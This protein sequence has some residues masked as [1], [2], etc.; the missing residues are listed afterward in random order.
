MSETPAD[1][2]FADYLTVGEAAAALGVSPWTLRNWDR[3]GKLRTLRH[4]KNGYR[5]YRREDLNAVLRP[6]IGAV[7]GG[8]PVLGDGNPGHF[9]QFF[10]NDTYLVATVGEFIGAALGRGEG[11]IVIATAAHRRGL[12]KSLTGRGID[13]ATA[14]QGGQYVALDAAVTLAAFMDGD[15]PDPQRF[16]EVVGGVVART[17]QGRAG[18]S[19]FGEMVALLWSAGNRAGAIRL[20][21]LWNDLARTQTFALLCAYP[22]SGFG[23]GDHVEG[24]ADVCA[25]HTRVLPAESF[26]RLPTEDDRLR[27]IS[28]LQQQARAL[29][30]E[31]ERRKAAE[32][33]LRLADRRKDEFLATLAHE[34]RNPLAP[35]CTALEVLQESPADRAAAEKAVATMGRQV[36]QLVRLVDDLLDVS[37]ITRGKVELRTERVALAAVVATAVEMSRPQIEAARH[38]LTVELPP[39]EL[40]LDADPARL[41]QMLSNLLNNAAKYTDAGGRIRVRAERQGDQV[42]V[43]VADTGIGIAPELLP[44]VF[45][46]FVQADGLAERANGGLGVGLALVKALAQLHGGTVEA[47]SDGPGRGSEFTLRLPLAPAAAPK[48][49][50]GNGRTAAALPR[51]RVLVVDDN[52]DAADSLATLL[53]LR[54]QDVRTAYDGPTGLA[55]ARDFR[56]DLAFLD[57][58]LPGMDGCELARALRADPAG[59][60][61]LL[62]ALTGW[63]QDE[64]RQQSHAAGFDEHHA[65]PLDLP[66]LEDLVRR[67]GPPA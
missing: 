6:V 19:A 61:T 63:G 8:Q 45:D 58:G 51:R 43:R 54:G 60:D 21:E 55:A 5:I 50:P 37:R 18:L 49:A 26:G 17:A 57:I 64:D 33:A 42:A 56:P 46:L 40:T 36:K 9:V 67:A 32:E 30:A 13:V 52:L 22:M 29:A 20:E 59:R 10:E 53:R 44:R 11:T 66:V 38:V 39:G 28:R 41:A 24:F 3:A 62:V 35:V 4:P 23:G 65:K 47:H 25:S 34:L 48:P 1:P 16:A 7:P 27:E 31:V 2:T 15:T 12:H 14:R